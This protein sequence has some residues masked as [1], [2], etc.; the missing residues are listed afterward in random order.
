M[1]QRI[2]SDQ[3]PE[4][5]LPFSQAIKAGDFVYVSGQVGV[6]PRTRKVVGESIEEQTAQTLSNIETILKAAGLTLDHVIKVNAF[7]SRLEDFPGYNQVYSTIMKQPFP[8]RS[9]IQ[10]GIGDYLVEIDVVAYAPSVR[11]ESQ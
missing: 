1:S 5:P 10:C 2:H 9:S 6:D 7:I 8:A 3:A 4:F 11:G